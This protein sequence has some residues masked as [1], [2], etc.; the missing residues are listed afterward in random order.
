MSRDIKTGGGVGVVD[1]HY[2]VARFKLAANHW[3]PR[4]Q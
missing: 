4:A 1:K 2:Q 3:L